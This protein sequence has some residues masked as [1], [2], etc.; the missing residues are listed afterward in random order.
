MAGDWNEERERESKEWGKGKER[1]RKSSVQPIYLIEN[2]ECTIT[3]NKK[4]IY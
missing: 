3:I 4:I 2:K 1:L